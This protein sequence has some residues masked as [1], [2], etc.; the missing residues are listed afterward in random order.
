MIIRF[1]KDYRGRKAGTTAD[2]PDDE[3]KKF[4]DAGAAEDP[5]AGDQPG[6]MRVWVR[7]GFTAPGDDDKPVRHAAGGFAVVRVTDEAWEAVNRGDADL[8]PPPGVAGQPFPPEF[9]RKSEATDVPAPPVGAVDP[10][11]LTPQPAAKPAPPK[12]DEE[13][14]PASGS[15]TAEGPVNK[16]PPKR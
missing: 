1:T 11:T 7:R 10:R 9:V 8:N 5:S 4:L 6:T 15:G 13:P 3:A 2:L 14:K 12:Q 16:L